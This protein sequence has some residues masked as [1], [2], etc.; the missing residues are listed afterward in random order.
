[1]KL[2][3]TQREQMRHELLVTPGGLEP[4]ANSLE[5]CCSIQLSYGAAAAGYVA[6]FR[7]GSKGRS[8]PRP[9]RLQA[10]A[11][12]PRATAKLADRFFRR[13]KPAAMSALRCAVSAVRRPVAPD[14]EG[15][16]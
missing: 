13:L 5:G 7:A 11:V 15:A 14:H 2:V 8:A 6:A 3:D 10:P 4:P 16:C 12:E 9:A 1:M